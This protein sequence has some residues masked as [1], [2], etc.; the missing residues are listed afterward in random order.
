MKHF[1]CFCEPLRIRAF[2]ADFSCHNSGSSGQKAQR[3]P[4]PN[5]IGLV[6]CNKI[7]LKISAH[8]GK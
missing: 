4:Y 2:V 3:I 5:D 8:E 7:A 6:S 1:R